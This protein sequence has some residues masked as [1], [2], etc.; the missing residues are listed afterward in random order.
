MSLSP[1]PTLGDTPSPLLGDTY[2]PKRGPRARRATV[3][4]TPPPDLRIAPTHEPLDCTFAQLIELYFGANPCDHMQGCFRKWLG[5]FQLG[6]LSAW[7]ITP[8]QLKAGAEYLRNVREYEASTINRELSQLGTIYRWAV[9]EKYAPLTWV[10]EPGQSPVTWVSPTLGN[11]G[12]VKEE[13]RRVEPPKPGEWQKIR[14]AARSGRDPLFT[15]FVWLVM[16]TGARRSE[17]ADRHWTALNFDEPEG[18]NIVV[19]DT[20]TGKPRRLYFSHDTAA[21]LKRLRPAEKYRAQL[22]FKSKRGTQPNQYRKPW[23]RLCQKIGRPGLHLH[24]LRHMLAADLLNAGKGMIPVSNLLGHSTLV[25]KRRYAHLDDASVRAIQAERLGL[26]AAP[27]T[28][29]APVREAR[30]RQAERQAAHSPMDEAQ[31]LALLAQD[32]AAAAAAAAAA[33]AAAQEAMRV[34]MGGAPAALPLVER[35]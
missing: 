12:R 3:V 23:A 2:V 29:F 33:L 24:D 34:A 11:S 28:E 22:I 7:A 17:V 5:W 14:L 26:D 9:D 8:E 16:E 6:E 10:R 4:D 20:K 35:K 18:P 15:A 32:A 31:R 13:M 30:M 27:P 25:L 19:M 1:S 21:L